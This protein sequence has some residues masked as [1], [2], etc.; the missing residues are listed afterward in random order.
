VAIDS[1]LDSQLN[2]IEQTQAQYLLYRE[3]L[4]PAREAAVARLA[5]K[6]NFMLAGSFEL[7]MA[8]QQ[9]Y[10]AYEG[11]LEALHDYWQAQLALAR[12]V[13]GPLPHIVTETQP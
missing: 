8:K 10:A 11:S 5:E 9:E 12:A 1:E 4:I 3:H 2:Q 7:L 6:V 13:G